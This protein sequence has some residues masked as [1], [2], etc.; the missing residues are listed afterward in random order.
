MPVRVI[1]LDLK[2]EKLVMQIT[3]QRFAKIAMGLSL[4]QRNFRL[5]FQEQ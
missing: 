2:K 3:F 4:Q 1:A 5:F